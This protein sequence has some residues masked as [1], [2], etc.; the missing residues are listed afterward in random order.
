MSSLRSPVTR[1]GFISGLQ[2][3]SGEDFTRKSIESEP[4]VLDCL[5]ESTILMLDHFSSRCAAMGIEVRPDELSELGLFSSFINYRVKPSDGGGVSCMSLWTEW[6]RFFLKHV[7]SFPNLIYEK[8]F[9]NLI[10]NRFGCVIANI[11]D[12]GP[13]YS[14][15]E[16][17]P[18]QKISIH[19]ADSGFAQA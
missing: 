1:E 15:I 2:C 3:E 13:V 4:L 8:E 14:G 17:V 18:E 12:C 5:S 19:L 7:N 11:E 9:K 6:V 16:F 10:L